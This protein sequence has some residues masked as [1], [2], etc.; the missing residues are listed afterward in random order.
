MLFAKIDFSILSNYLRFFFNI[1]LET[2]GVLLIPFPQKRF[3]LHVSLIEID[4]VVLEEK[5]SFTQGCLVSSLVE[6]KVVLKKKIKMRKSLQ[7]RLERSA[8]VS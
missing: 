5:I 8:S 3:V 4:T 6:I 1:H 7:R 2:C